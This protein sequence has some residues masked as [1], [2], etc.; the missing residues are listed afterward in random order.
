MITP[1]PCD[2]DHC[3]LPVARILNGVLIIESRHH[4][5]VHRGTISLHWLQ[6]LLT[7]RDTSAT[8]R[9]DG[10]SQTLAPPG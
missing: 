1:I 7:S 5:K 2:D 8:L 10:V 9:L 6:N 3:N 4:G